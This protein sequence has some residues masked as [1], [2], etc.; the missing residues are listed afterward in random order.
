MSPSVVD[1]ILVPNLTALPHV[2]TQNKWRLRKFNTR[3]IPK[4][5]TVASR[6]PKNHPILSLDHFVEDDG[7]LGGI[8]STRIPNQ[9]VLITS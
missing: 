5:L 8:N 6:R 2:S 9:L 7:I 1:G 3:H 4:S